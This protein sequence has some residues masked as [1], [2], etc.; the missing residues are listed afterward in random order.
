[1]MRRLALLALTIG[2][3]AEV[4]PS[5]QQSESEISRSE[6]GVPLQPAGLMPLWRVGDAWIVRYH[7]TYTARNR[8]VVSTDY[9]WEHRV[10]WIAGGYVAITATHV[11]TIP[12]GTHRLQGT[13]RLRYRMN[14]ELVELTPP[15]EHDRIPV[16]PKV[17]FPTGDEWATDADRYGWPQFPLVEG[18][19]VEFEEG[20]DQTVTGEEG[21]LRVTLTRRYEYE[22][23]GFEGDFPPR[24]V[25]QTMDQLW[26]PNHPWW[27]SIRIHVDESLHL[28]GDVIEWRPAKQ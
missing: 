8:K 14:A 1:M 27:S 13:T 2:C 18:S 21:G 19:R 22:D 20:F 26:E 23:R 15:R 10:E 11:N 5:P 3:S 7:T 6:V 9:D 28:E 4:L 16:E 25:V 17:H 24:E 12:R